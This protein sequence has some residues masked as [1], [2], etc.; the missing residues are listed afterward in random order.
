MLITNRI[1]GNIM[2]STGLGHNISHTKAQIQHSVKDPEKRKL[3]LK[4]LERLRLGKPQPKSEV[5]ELLQ[6]LTD[7]NIVE[8]KL[9]GT[10]L[11]TTAHNPEKVIKAAARAVHI[12]DHEHMM[13]NMHAQQE[14]LKRLA[15]ETDKER[16][17]R[18]K[19]EKNDA[20]KSKMGVVQGG[21][22]DSAPHH[23]GTPISQKL[24]GKKAA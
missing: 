2:K 23:N 7:H 14:E 6:D 1:S 24:G 5:K 18:E 4:R 12:E 16:E 22:T 10:Y 8:E 11:A 13:E 21:R 9:T 3:I 19:K 17:E 20:Q 15:N